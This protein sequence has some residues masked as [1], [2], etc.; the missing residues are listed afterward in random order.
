MGF[1]TN[2]TV[3]SH[4]QKI[5][6]V[7]NHHSKVADV[8]RQLSLLESTKVKERNI[9]LHRMKATRLRVASKSCGDVTEREQLYQ[10]ATLHAAKLVM[11]QID[12]S[13][14]ESVIHS[15]NGD[16]AEKIDEGQQHT[17]KGLKECDC[18]HFTTT[19]LPCVHI[20]IARNHVGQAK[21]VRELVPER[22]LKTMCSQ[23]TNRMMSARV[24]YP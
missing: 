22:C 24:I 14:R 19:G 17:V 11:A 6:I 15:A 12:K 4:N 13:C 8:I 3:E 23:C 5:K 21:F 16:Y 1:T 20:F 9:H 10:V 2:N 7:L 18:S